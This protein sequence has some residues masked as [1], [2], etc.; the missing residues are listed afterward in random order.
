MLR[1]MLQKNSTD[2]VKQM[3]F[4][5][6]TPMLLPQVMTSAHLQQ[7]LHDLKQL[8]DRLG[9]RLYNEKHSNGCCGAGG[10]AALTKIGRR[11]LC[12]V[13]LFYV[14]KNHAHF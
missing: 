3:I 14:N 2:N 10:F 6:H 11:S 4:E 12:C 1:E 9:F 5:I 7:V 13:E 8:Q